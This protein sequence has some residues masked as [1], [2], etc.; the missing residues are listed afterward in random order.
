MWTEESENHIAR[1]D[2]RPSEVEALVN[3]RPIR[4]AVGREGC[5][6]IY[7]VTSAGRH[8]LVVLAESVDGRWHVV[9]ARG[10]TPREKSVFR[11]KEA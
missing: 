11:R 7:G 2:V 9:T 1:H 4:V 6:L 3:S 8:L 10:M 5:S